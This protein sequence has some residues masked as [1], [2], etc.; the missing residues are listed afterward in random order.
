VLRRAV[1]ARSLVR[2]ADLFV[3]AGGTMT[4]EAALL[5]TPTL[6]VF[7]GE[8]AAVDTVLEQRGLLRRLR[9]AADV[10]AVAPRSAPP[11]ALDELRARSGRLVDVFVEET[12]RA[13]RLKAAA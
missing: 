6:S 3:G 12:L 13:G 4:R 7:G 8:D 5:G 1:D 2:K 9:S 10:D 11:T